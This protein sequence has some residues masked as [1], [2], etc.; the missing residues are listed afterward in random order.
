MSSSSMICASSSSLRQTASSSASSISSTRCSVNCPGALKV[1]Y[2]AAPPEEN[3]RQGAR[4]SGL[5]DEAARRAHPL[6]GS[7]IEVVVGEHPLQRAL[8]GSVFQAEAAVFEGLAAW[9]PHAHRELPRLLPVWEENQ[10][11]PF[12]EG[13]VGEL[14][15]ASIT[16]APTSP[17]GGPES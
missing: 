16:G 9:A 2:P 13:N 14:V 5:F 7:S 10:V 17:G 11:L 6:L 3:P 4:G 8:G 12:L 15:P 1:S